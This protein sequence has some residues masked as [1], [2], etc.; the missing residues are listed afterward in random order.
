MKKNVFDSCPKYLG[1]LTW[2][3][4]G[5]KIIFKG[6]YV[7]FFVFYETLKKTGRKKFLLSLS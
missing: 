5:I 3:H 1:A 4:P 6:F 2:N 7:L